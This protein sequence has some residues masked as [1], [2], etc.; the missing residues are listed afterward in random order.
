MLTF[1]FKCLCLVNIVYWLWKMWINHRQG[2]TRKIFF[3]KYYK[4]FCDF[5]TNERN[6]IV[7]KI[8][9]YLRKKITYKNFH[10]N[11]TKINFQCIFRMKKLFP[12]IYFY[13]LILLL[14]KSSYWKWYYQNIN[15]CLACVYLQNKLGN[16][17]P[18]LFNDLM[19]YLRSE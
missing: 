3:R 11:F 5:M 10:S 17:Q 15:G 12:P 9:R 6:Y 18:K 14:F 19:R 7:R 8:S 4:K 13:G 1:D 2:P 16:A